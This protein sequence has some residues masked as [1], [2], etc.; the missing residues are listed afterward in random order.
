MTGL[1]LWSSSKSTEKVLLSSLHTLAVDHE[2]DLG[3]LEVPNLVCL[4]CQRTVKDWYIP[5]V[6]PGRLSSFKGGS[7]FF[8]QWNEYLV[9]NDADCE[10][11]PRLVALELTFN[12][13]YPFPQLSRRHPTTENHYKTLLAPL[14]FS[15]L[16]TVSFVGMAYT[17]QFGTAALD[18]FMLDILLCPDHCPQLHTIQS[19]RYPNW[20]L[21][22]AM[23]YR[24]NSFK[25]VT[26]VLSF[27]LPR[28]PQ[29]GILE[30]ITRALGAVDEPLH[31]ILSAAVG[32]D[33]ILKQRWEMYIL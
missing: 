4:R 8:Y 19:A 3:Y 2:A 13:L 33:Q 26:P 22:A 14:S 11:F 24:R 12:S 5:D 32:M 21:A 16:R 6:L 17:G 9:A 23:F 1:I 30:M 25:E 18:Y 31:D 27:Q 7:F 10:P 15:N 29:M 20:A 28:Y